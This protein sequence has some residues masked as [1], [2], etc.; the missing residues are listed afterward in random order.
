MLAYPPKI[1]NSDFSKTLP[2][3]SYIINEWNNELINEYMQI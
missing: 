1:F 2:Q 3:N